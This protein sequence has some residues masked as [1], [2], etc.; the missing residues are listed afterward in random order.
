MSLGDFFRKLFVAV[1][2]PCIPEAAQQ[3]EASL[4][5]LDRDRKRTL[6]DIIALSKLDSDFGSVFEPVRSQRTSMNR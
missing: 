2:P 4:S 5:V 3:M 1:T 6:T